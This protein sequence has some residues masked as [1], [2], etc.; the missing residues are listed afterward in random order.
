VVAVALVEQ[1]ETLEAHRQEVITV[2]AVVA[3]SIRE[4]IPITKAVEVVA[5]Q[6]VQVVMA[7]ERIEEVMVGQVF[8]V[9]QHWHLAVHLP[10][11]VIP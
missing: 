9:V 8:F 2:V 10:H 1:V 5:D 7:L 3:V 6:E 4:E 11:M